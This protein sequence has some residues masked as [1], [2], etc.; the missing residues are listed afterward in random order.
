MIFFNEDKGKIQNEFVE[1]EGQIDKLINAT[2]QLCDVTRKLPR[3]HF[4]GFKRPIRAAVI[5]DRDTKPVE[6]A[7]T[8]I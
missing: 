1:A 8:R 5:E 7:Y 6:V 2:Q 4:A 3:G